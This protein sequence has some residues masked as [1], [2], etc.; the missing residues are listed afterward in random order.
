[1]WLPCL[2]TSCLLISVTGNCFI[3]SNELYCCAC[4]FID[5]LFGVPGKYTG[6][7]HYNRKRVVTYTITVVL[8]SY[9]AGW[10]KRKISVFFFLGFHLLYSQKS[11]QLLFLLWRINLPLRYKILACISYSFRVVFHVITQCLSHASEYSFSYL[12]CP[13]LLALFCDFCNF[14]SVC[15]GQN[16][17]FNLKG[18]PD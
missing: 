15:C 9:D 4:V 18:L 17:D 1:M 2:L 12:N 11:H 7:S 10:V 13:L 14:V 6:V 3:C 16:R 8:S 5:L